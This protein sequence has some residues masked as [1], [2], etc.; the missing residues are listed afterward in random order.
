MEGMGGQAE[1]VKKS[2]SLNILMYGFNIL[3]LNMD[4]IGVWKGEQ[5]KLQVC[6][7]IAPER[8]KEL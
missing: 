3:E 1:Y 7:R 5:M 6:G 4:L 8:E 2:E